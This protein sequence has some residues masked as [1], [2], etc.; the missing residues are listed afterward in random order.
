VH[1][2]EILAF[3]PEEVN[4]YLSFLCK[5]TFDIY[6]VIIVKHCWEKNQKLK[7]VYIIY[8]KKRGSD[9]SLLH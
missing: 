7:I 1:G 5:T 8:L 2:K 3:F 9:L 4:S 6:V